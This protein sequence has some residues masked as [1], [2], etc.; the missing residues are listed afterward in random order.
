[1]TK[2][3]RV[4]SNQF[5]VFLILFLVGT[6]V[7]TSYLTSQDVVAFSHCDEPPGP[8]VNLSGCD[9][10]DKNFINADFSFNGTQYSIILANRRPSGKMIEISAIK[11]V[12]GRILLNT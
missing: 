11:S 12:W 8:S 7:L 5:S 10:S 9:L 4:S 2:N 3:S 1:M 6:I